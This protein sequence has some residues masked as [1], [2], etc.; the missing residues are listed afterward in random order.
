MANILTKLSRS[1]LCASLSTNMLV[2]YK[3]NSMHSEKIFEPSK[4]CRVSVSDSRHQERAKFLSKGEKEPEIAALRE[5]VL[6]R[7]RLV[8]AK[9]KDEISKLI[10]KAGK[11]FKGKFLIQS[12]TMLLRCCRREKAQRRLLL[13]MREW[14][15]LI[16]A[17]GCSCK[18]IRQY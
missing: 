6:Q 9:N 7:Q 4:G 13:I 14:Q 15:S 16:K 18:D 1:V 11:L 3:R 12:I 8:E 10:A 17:Q 5:R 2:E